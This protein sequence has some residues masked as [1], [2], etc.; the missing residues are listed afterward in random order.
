[1]SDW[2]RSGPNSPCPVCS[3]THDADC[4][5][6]TDGNVVLCHTPTNPGSNVPQPGTEANGFRTEGKTVNGGCCGERVV[7][8]RVDDWVKPQRKSNGKTHRFYYSKTFR[9]CRRDTIERKRIWQEWQ[10]DDGRWQRS[11]IPAETKESAPLYCINDP[12]NRR[13]IARHTPILYV[14]GEGIV[15]RLLE[16]GQAA[17]TNIGGAGKWK[18]YGGKSGLYV[19]AL[20]GA[21]LVLCPDCDTP[22]IEHCGQIAKDFPSTKWL[23]AQPD[24]FRWNNPYIGSKFDLGDWLDLLQDEGL[25]D[26]AIVNLLID[27]I[28]PRRSFDVELPAGKDKQK[29]SK[30]RSRR[31]KVEATEEKESRLGRDYR[32]FKQ[33]FGDRIAVNQ[34]TKNIEFDGQPV[35]VDELKVLI[36]DSEDYECRAFD[37]IAQQ[38]AKQNQ[39]SPVERYLSGLPECEDLAI[40]EDLATRYLNDSDPLYNIYVK[41]WLIAA[42]ARALDPGCKVDTALI[43]QGSQGIGKSTFF[44]VLAGQWF[45]DSLGSMSDKDERLK[46]HRAWVVEWAELESIFKRRDVAAVKAFLSSSADYIRLPYERTVEEMPRHSVIVGS[47]NQ[48]EFL[49]DPTGSRRFWVIPCNQAID[50]EL[51]RSERDRIWAAAVAAYRAGEQWWLTTEEQQQTNEASE[52]YEVSDPW[53]V[54][55]A[56]WLETATTITTNKILTDCLNRDLADQKKADEMRVSSILQRLGYEQ[57]KKGGRKVIGGERVRIWVEKTPEPVAIQTNLTNLTN[58]DQ[59]SFGG[60]SGAETQTEKAIEGGVTNLTNLNRPQTPQRVAPTASPTTSPSVELNKKGFIGKKVGQVGQKEERKTGQGFQ[61]D[62]PQN[63]RLVKVGQVG[64]PEEK[65]CEVFV[66]GEWNNSHRLVR[67][68]GRSIISAFSGKIQPRVRIRRANGS[69]FEIAQDCVRLVEGQTND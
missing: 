17:T 27:S 19:E 5:W 38:T 64:Q 13:A 23:Y 41:K 47:T 60:W 68:T 58:P 59:P 49:A 43:L 28:E 3:R 12:V 16:L 66:D 69:T 63:Q 67:D 52:I 4:E 10:D 21:N 56:A 45:D 35:T 14:E 26:A 31:R 40:L 8:H 44:K 65:H 42:V 30:T 15:D 1:M 53:D 6:S 54:P 20:T 33:L 7:Y 51:L 11:G 37:L 2:I 61:P 50:I 32:Q 24:H 46:L 29:A 48:E 62:Q 39:Y 55:I 18:A 57:P 9:V 25:D 34:L 22:G 36:A